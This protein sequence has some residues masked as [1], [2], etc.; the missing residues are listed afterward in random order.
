VFAILLVETARICIGLKK[1]VSNQLVRKVLKE[2]SCLPFLFIPSFLTKS[3][4]VMDGVKWDLQPAAST[5]AKFCVNGLK[6]F[7]SPR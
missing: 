3:I 6:P 1:E 4:Q 5:K 2:K 7:F